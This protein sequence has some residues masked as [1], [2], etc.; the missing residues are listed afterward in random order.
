MATIRAVN[1]ATRAAT[2]F[3][4]IRCSAAILAKRYTEDHEWIELSDDKKTGTIGISTYAAKALG[5]VVY[6]E[7]PTT[8]LEVSAGDAIG[9][10]ESVK[11][12]SDIMTPISGKIIEAN[13]VLEDKPGTINR[14]P[15]DEGWMA[16]IEVTDAAEVDKLMDG[17]G[18]QDGDS[19]SL[20]NP[21][22]AT[23]PLI[24]VYATTTV[25]QSPSRDLIFGQTQ[26]SSPRPAMPAV[27]RVLSIIE[28]L[29]LI[30]CPTS[31]ADILRCQRVSSTFKDV[32][33]SLPILQE[34]LFMKPASFMYS[35]G[36]ANEPQPDQPLL[37]ALGA[38]YTG[39]F[40]TISFAPIAKEVHRYRPDFRHLFSL[41]HAKSGQASEYK[42]T[43]ARFLEE[44]DSALA[45]SSQGRTL[46][47]TLVWE[48]SARS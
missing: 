48:R 16:R 21:V 18:H 5:D 11:S 27:L 1:T 33:D 19:G 42:T 20:H 29:E 28:L 12:A 6:V 37:S 7:L 17:E 3:S 23:G 40:R 36:E 8:D 26:K 4:P 34:K 15:E 44:I 46:P 13:A 32:I 10:V 47:E 43:E 22:S 9:A 35:N 39:H 2:N 45:T 25:S 14:S 30:L 31:M 41:E 38:E 24:H